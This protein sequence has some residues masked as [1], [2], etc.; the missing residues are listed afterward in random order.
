MY[1]FNISHRTK[2]SNLSDLFLSL[3]SETWHWTQHPPCPCCPLFLWHSCWFTSASYSTPF[4]V[5]YQY[6]LHWTL[7]RNKGPTVLPRKGG[8]KEALVAAL[9]VFDV[10]GNLF[11]GVIFFSLHTFQR[12]SNQP[13]LFTW[14]D[15]RQMQEPTETQGAPGDKA[16]A[17]ER[18][19]QSVTLA[20]SA[21]SWNCKQAFQ[22]QESCIVQGQVFLKLRHK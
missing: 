14:R 11:V 9:K 17:E 4:S 13:D 15:G 19:Y 21:E 20:R 18:V 10:F 16:W 3:D 12:W 2:H 1:F 22:S 5:L 7:R 6:F 8:I